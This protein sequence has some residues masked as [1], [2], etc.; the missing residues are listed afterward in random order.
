MYSQILYE[1]AD[2]VAVVTLNRPEKLNVFSGTMADELYDAFDRSQKDKDVGAI[3]FT[4]A[5]R[6]FCGGMDLQAL[7][8]P[9]ERE[10][11]AKSPFLLKFPQENW[12]SPKP[13]ICA[14]NGTAVGVGITM[15][16]SFDIR[17]GSENSKYS[18]PFIKLGLLPGF[19][20]SRM[21]QD[22]V[23]RSRALRL[24]QTGEMIDAPEAL[25]IGLIDKMVP[26]GEALNAARAMAKT[27]ASYDPFVLGLLKRSVNFSASHP[28]IEEVLENE[29]RLSAELLSKRSPPIPKRGAH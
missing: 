2:R 7:G 3:V 29:S 9:A 21:L 16:V 4:G 22:L 6:G 5:G 8:D 25:R 20:G 10:K 28:D 19:G 13:T 12:N 27:M 11:V 23:G 15:A 17:I 18:V 14:F 24:L 1:V 26:A